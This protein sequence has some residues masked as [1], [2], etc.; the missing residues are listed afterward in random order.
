MNMSD[1]SQDEMKQF[2]NNFV[3]R[4]N[5]EELIDMIEYLSQSKGL[6]NTYEFAFPIIIKFLK[7]NEKKLIEENIK[8]K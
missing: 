5:K 2:V 3:K 6:K 4:K 1:L 8:E 7:E